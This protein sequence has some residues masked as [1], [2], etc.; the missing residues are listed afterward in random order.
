MVITDNNLKVIL[1]TIQNARVIAD[2]IRKVIYYLIS[3]SLQE[4]SLIMLAISFCLPLPLSA[5][6]ILWINIVTDGV[7]D[8]MFAFARAEGNVMERHPHK[9]EKQVFDLSQIF[10]YFIVWSDFRISL[11]YPIS[12]SPSALP[13]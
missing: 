11:F 4:L 9:P 5:I 8:K 6:Q 10:K 1:E 7:Q 2:N 13:L 3:T 12:L